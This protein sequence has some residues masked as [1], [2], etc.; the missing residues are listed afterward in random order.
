MGLYNYFGLSDDLCKALYGKDTDQI[1]T[2]EN[3][4]G[5]RQPSG[6]GPGGPVSG[7]MWEA[8]S[9]NSG[10]MHWPW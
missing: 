8:I 2:G 9:I 10:A 7:N 1:G 3:G 5:R 6:A 4:C